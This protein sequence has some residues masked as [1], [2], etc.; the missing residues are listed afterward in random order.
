MTWN[1]AIEKATVIG[2]YSL[3][4]YSI[5]L[6][7]NGKI[8]SVDIPICNIKIGTTLRRVIQESKATVVDE[9]PMTNKLIF[10]ALDRTLTNT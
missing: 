8:T 4:K 3:E 6:K 2:V 1:S 5:C 7:C 10:E 9:A